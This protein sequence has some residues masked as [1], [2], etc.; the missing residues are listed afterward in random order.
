MKENEKALVLDVLAK[1]VKEL[2][3]ES[4]ERK[5]ERQ[6]EKAP[7]KREPRG[8]KVYEERKSPYVE[9]KDNASKDVFSSV[10]ARYSKVR[11]EKD[12][13]AKYAET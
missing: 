1:K 7:Q 3:Q 4:E 13:Y 6:P 9:K 11:F 12:N 2:D 8:E 5:E 10:R